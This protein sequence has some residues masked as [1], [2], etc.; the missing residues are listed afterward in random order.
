MFE[1]AYS[2]ILIFRT[3]RGKNGLKKQEV[4]EIGGKI[5]EN[6]YPRE[7]KIGLR[8]DGYNYREVLSK[9]NKNWFEKSFV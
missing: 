7:T 8:N 2:R 4:Q 1:Y 9:G 5:T 6:Y 3:S